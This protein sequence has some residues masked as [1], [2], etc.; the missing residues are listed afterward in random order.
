MALRWVIPSGLVLAL[1][2]VGGLLFPFQDRPGEPE[3]YRS[4]NITLAQSEEAVEH[5]SKVG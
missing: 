3:R 4:V 2:I 1:A 5:L